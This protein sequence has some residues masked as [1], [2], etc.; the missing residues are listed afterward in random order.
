[1]K[2]L[3][4]P[5]IEVSIPRLILL[6]EIELSR[7]LSN[8]YHNPNKGKLGFLGEIAA[9][10]PYLGSVFQ[11]E[12]SQDDDLKGRD[13]AHDS[14]W[15]SCKTIDTFS[16]EGARNRKVWLEHPKNDDVKN[17]DKYIFCLV[18]PTRDNPKWAIVLDIQDRF[19]ADENSEFFWQE[20]PKTGDREALRYLSLYENYPILNE[21]LK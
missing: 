18:H 6:S 16:R 5:T 17:F 3:I 4:K 1:M 19:V 2:G 14:L 7:N 21:L 13:I 9:A 8:L 12:K 15:Y 10:C 20:D 11:K